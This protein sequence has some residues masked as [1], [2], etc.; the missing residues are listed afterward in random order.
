MAYES[1]SEQCETMLAQ[2]KPTIFNN[3]GWGM[4]QVPLF[5]YSL[6]DLGFTKNAD[7]WIST[8]IEI[9]QRP[10]YK[11][12]TP[13]SLLELKKIAETFKPTL[14]IEIGTSSGMSLRT[15]L[16]LDDVRVVAIDL[17]FSH[18]QTSHKHLP[19]DSSRL[20]LFETDIMK[21]DISELWDENERVLVFVDAHDIPG[22]PIMEK[23]LLQAFPN[24][25]PQNLVVVD[26][27]WYSSKL[28]TKDNIG[29]YFDNIILKEIDPTQDFAGK[30]AHYWEGGSFFG[31]DEAI[32]LMSWMNMHKVKALHHFGKC[33]Y[34][35]YPATIKSSK[36]I[37]PE[38][39]CCDIAYVPP[40]SV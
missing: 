14:I 17:S 8:V 28:L 2:G 15:W 34:F 9:E 25:P 23:L 29:P 18:L 37:R 36:T 20:K 16:S 13:R 35:S 10:N 26:D 6:A 30:A 40:V 21:M 39:Y 7:T 33:L 38:E 24:L 3:E 12:Q 27:L 31:F 5:E 32:P 4:Q 19:I 1:Y 11:D 22:V